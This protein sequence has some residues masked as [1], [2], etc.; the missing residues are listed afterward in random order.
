MDYKGKKRNCLRSFLLGKRK[1]KRRKEMT[2][3]TYSFAAWIDIEA[4]NI[5]EAKE[6]FSEQVRQI[7]RST[8]LEI[9]ADY[10]PKEVNGEKL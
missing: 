5:T 3:D 9:D 4:E 7:N 1:K 6:L 10:S 2:L 8:L